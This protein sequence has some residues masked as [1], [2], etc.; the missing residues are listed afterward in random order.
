MISM[1]IDPGFSNT[2][3]V[4]LKKEKKT[5]ETIDFGCIVTKPIKKVLRHGIRI[6][7]DDSRRAME[8]SDHLI[9][10]L[11]KKTPDVIGIETFSLRPKMGK[12]WKTA[13]GYAIA[14]CSSRIVNTTVLTFTPSDIKSFTG[15][16]TASK[17]KV[18]ESVTSLYLPK[19]DWSSVKE[20]HKEHIGDACA[21]SVMAAEQFM[22]YRSKLGIK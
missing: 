12:A 8:I 4:I 20:A 18:R 13:F 19:F 15:D 11:R 1:G 9:G 2:G 22:E 5:Y 3:W 10:L 16:K 7:D 21:L 17:K 6:T 14:L